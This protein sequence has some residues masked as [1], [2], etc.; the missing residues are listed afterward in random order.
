[1]GSIIPVLDL[2]A[3]AKRIAALMGAV[4]LFGLMLVVDAQAVDSIGLVKTSKGSVTIE[5]SGQKI[6]A[7]GGTKLYSSDQVQTG[8]DGAVGMTFID[9]SRLSLGA[10]SILAL[11]KFRFNTTT[12]E[13]EFVSSV[14]R[15]TL[16]AVSGKIAKQTPEAMQVRTPSAI[17]GV[18]GT[19]FV[20]EV[21]E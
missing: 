1:M 12:H 18:R 16:A 13:G 17:L 4:A 2:T 19:K 21:P 10:N 7:P 20:V 5:R 6:A 15:G 3:L 9:N 8:A 14:K 11:E